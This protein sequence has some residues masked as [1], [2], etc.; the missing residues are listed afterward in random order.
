VAVAIREVAERIPTQPPA[1]RQVV[2]EAVKFLEPFSSPAKATP[3]KGL[4]PSAEE[5]ANAFR[6]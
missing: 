4:N 1:A 5:V 6:S 2:Y 3:T